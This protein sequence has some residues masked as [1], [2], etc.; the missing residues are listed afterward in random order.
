MIIRSPP[1]EMSQ[2]LWSEL[3]RGPRATRQRCHAMTDAQI[4]PL[5]E[6]S[7]Q[8]S[9][10]AQSLQGGCEICLGPQADHRRDPYEFAPPVGFLHLA[11]DQTGRYLPLACFALSTTSCEPLPEMGCESIEIQM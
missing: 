5:D 11:V 9:R 4:H 6:S 2:Q 1:L 8:P 7:V 3:R 10:Q